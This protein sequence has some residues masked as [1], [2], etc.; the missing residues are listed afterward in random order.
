MILSRRFPVM[1]ELVVRDAR[2]ST[3]STG[4]IHFNMARPERLLAA[5][6]AYPSL[7]TRFADA[8]LSN[9]G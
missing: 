1:Q 6:A 9:S 8:N 4:P 7:G 2:E 3:V 5:I